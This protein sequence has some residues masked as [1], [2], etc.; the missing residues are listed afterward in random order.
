MSKTENERLRILHVVAPGECG[1]LEKVVQVL[2]AGHRDEGH[3]VQVVSITDES[4]DQHPFNAALRQRGVQ[5]IPITLPPRAYRKEWIRMRSICDQL[6]PEVVHT[7][8]YRPDVLDSAVARRLGIPTVAT[9]HGFTGGGLKNRLYERLQRAAFRRFAAIVAVSQSLG[10]RLRGSGVPPERLHIIQNLWEPAEPLLDR[11][12]ARRALGV[13][14]DGYRIGWVGRLSAE[15]GPDLFLEAVALLSDLPIG[16]SIV[17][18]GMQQ[19]HLVARSSELGVDERVTWHGIVPDAGRFFRA[20]D[21]FVLSSRT[22]GTPI[23]IL[24]AM[25]GEVPIVAARVGGIPE[26]VAADRALVVSSGDPRALADAIRTIYGNPHIALRR[27]RAARAAM[28]V[29]FGLPQW[30]ARYESVY[31]Q[32]TMKASSGGSG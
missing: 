11:V 6:Q 23:T 16:A 12:T 26:L 7:H 13:P 8:G 2:T 14:T 10:K 3:D 1:G 24:E 28:R 5:V 20:F 27:A 15:K 4:P 31:R 22:E 21:I 32:V 19:D 9:V 30:L 18:G 25:A 29:E 17:G